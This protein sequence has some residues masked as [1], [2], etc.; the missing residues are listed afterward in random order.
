MQTEDI[1]D[2]AEDLLNDAGDYLDTYYKLTLVN[3]TQ[4]VSIAASSVV[5]IIAIAAVA[6][7][8]ILFAALGL[9]W[10]VGELV[11]SRA[12]GFFIVGGFFLL[13]LLLILA[14]RKKIIFPFI[15]NLIVR[16]LYD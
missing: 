7:F 11:N 9:S 4:K 1:K 16:N 15:R 5:S 12:G 13:L 3:V 10:W 6:V 14:F 2:K 8:V